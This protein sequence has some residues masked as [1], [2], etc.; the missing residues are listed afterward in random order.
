MTPEHFA[1]RHPVLYHVAPAANW[2]CI[3]RHGLL[4]TSALLER[5]HVSADRR[6]SIE[7]GHRREPT[8]ITCPEC[9]RTLTIRDQRPMSVKK[10]QSC[11][12]DMTVQEWFRL[13]NGMVFFWAEAEDATH[14][15]KA[16]AGSHQCLIQLRAADLLAAHVDRVAI[17][18]INSG[19][20]YYAARQRG[21]DTFRPL[22]MHCDTDRIVEV[23]IKNAV[24]SVIDFVM[25][26][27][28]VDANGDRSLLWEPS[29][30]RLRP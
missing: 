5:C 12:I 19:S 4:S 21:R 6:G 10:L 24:E 30:A 8:Q 11:L 14:F 28:A 20:T 23:T 29:T 22:T 7:A 18:P 27:D 1:H 25:R 9:Q 2:P 17:S 3:R 16:Y 26:V 15:L 13:L